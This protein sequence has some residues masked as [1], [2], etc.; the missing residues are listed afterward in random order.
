MFTLII[1]LLDVCSS[2]SQSFRKNKILADMVED[3]GLVPHLLSMEVPLSPRVLRVEPPS[4]TS[5][6]IIDSAR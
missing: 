3:F 6:I 1:A 5:I 2:F 4:F